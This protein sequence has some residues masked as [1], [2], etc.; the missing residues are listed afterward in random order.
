MA[1]RLDAIGGE[2]VVESAPGSGTRVAGFV[3][4]REVVPA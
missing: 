4:V 1:D 3:S 2:L